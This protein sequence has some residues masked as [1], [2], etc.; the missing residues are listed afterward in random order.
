MLLGLP[1]PSDNNISSFLGN[2]D[3]N[4]SDSSCLTT[5]M[6]SNLDLVSVLHKTV[7]QKRYDKTTNMVT[8]NNYV[9]ITGS[10]KSDSHKSH[11]SM[12]Y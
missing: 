8:S 12:N 11:C 9:M 10:F 7:S 1:T 4:F 2:F 5:R 3:F 6:T